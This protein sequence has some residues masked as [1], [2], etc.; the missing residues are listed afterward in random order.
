[1]QQSAFDMNTKVGQTNFPLF[2]F[3]TAVLCFLISALGVTAGAHRLW[4]HRSYKAAL[5]LRIFLGVANS[6][7]FQASKNDCSA[8]TSF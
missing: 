3:S 1:M 4:S 8:D 2:F 5:P 7:A 6:M